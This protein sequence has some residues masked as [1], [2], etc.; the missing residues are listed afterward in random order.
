MKLEN[1]SGIPFDE[2][3][4]DE[5]MKKLRHMYE[6]PLDFRQKILTDLYGDLLEKKSLKILE[7]GF[8]WGR[9]AQ[10]FR[11]M[12]NVKFFGFDPSTTG[13]EYFKKMGFPEDRF[14]VSLNIDKKILSQKYDLIFSTY[15]LQH[16]GF[17]TP[18]D[19][20]DSA[21]IFATVSKLLKKKGLMFFHE[22]HT[23][24]MS[25]SRDRFKQLIVDH[26]FEL[27]FSPR[28]TLLG[29]DPHPHDLFLVKK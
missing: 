2:C 12:E 4:S 22:L 13:M 27:D 14:Y 29:G 10:F 19:V 20:H 18:D 23:G 1:V 7:I 15:V 11:D 6:T 8:G 9:N 3:D 28:V 16:V 26:G 21:S 17:G 24:Q 5:N 25:W